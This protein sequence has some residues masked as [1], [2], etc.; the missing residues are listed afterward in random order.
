ME[1]QGGMSNGL[2][3]Q[4]V[5]VERR[6]LKQVWLYVWRKLKATEIQTKGKSIFPSKR[7]GHKECNV[8]TEIHALCFVVFNQS[9][10]TR[11]VRRHW[12]VCN[13]GRPHVSC[14]VVSLFDQLDFSKAAL[15]RQFSH[16]PSVGRS[17]WLKSWLI[18]FVI[19]PVVIFM[20][21]WT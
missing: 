14:E 18:L 6:S 11:R 15:W 4:V 3:R 21:S 7:W 10:D 12:D 9:P 20:S 5:S 16:L 13:T 1:L 19:I 8:I 2:Y 17:E